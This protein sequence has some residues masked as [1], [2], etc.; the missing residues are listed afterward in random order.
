M[1]EINVKCTDNNEKGARLICDGSIRGNGDDLRREMVGALLMFDKIA[2][3]DILCDALCEFIEEK[4][5]R[6]YGRKR[7]DD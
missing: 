7:D 3:G 6:K 4:M 5:A 2:D 1:I